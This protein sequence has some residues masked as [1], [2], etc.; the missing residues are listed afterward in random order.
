MQRLQASISHTTRRKRV[1]EI[2]DRDYFFTDTVAFQ[3]MVENGQF[4]EHADVF[5]NYY[6][7]SKHWV[8]EQLSVGIDIILEIDWRG[9]AQIKRLMSNCVRIFILPPSFQALEDRLLSRGLDDVEIIQQRMCY[10]AEEISHCHEYDF[11]VINDDFKQALG[12]LQDI[13]ATL[14]GNRHIHK[15]D[16]S[17]FTAKLIAEAENFQ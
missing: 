14:R 9:A 2:E 1:E 4:L 12:E 8:C 17:Q 16:I 13:I 7:T 6:G 5:G 3:N 11:W 10:A 15:R